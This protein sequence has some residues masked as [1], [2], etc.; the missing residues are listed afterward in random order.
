MTLIYDKLPLEDDGVS[1]TTPEVDAWQSAHEPIVTI[2]VW[3]GKNDLPGSGTALTRVTWSAEAQ[4]P[5]EIVLRPLE[6]M[7]AAMTAVHNMVHQVEG[8][9]R[10]AAMQRGALGGDEA[11]KH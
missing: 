5:A 9:I 11:T 1:M 8:A 2:K 4:T 10:L 7:A 6:E 3:L